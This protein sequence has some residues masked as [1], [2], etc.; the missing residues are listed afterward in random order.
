MIRRFVLI[1]CAAVP[2]AG[3]GIGSV[4][5]PARDGRDALGQP[6]YELGG[7]RLARLEA[8]ANSNCPG[9]TRPYYRS[10]TGTGDAVKRSGGG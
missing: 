5:S 7:D 2:C 6:V 10:I 1:A 9:G 4:D 8:V 3:C